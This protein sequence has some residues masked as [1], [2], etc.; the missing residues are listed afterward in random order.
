MAGVVKSIERLD[1]DN[2]RTWS[3]KMKAVLVTKELWTPVTED[4]PTDKK[5]DQKALALITL[6]VSDHNLSTL[7]EAETA[8]AAWETL[9]KVYE[10]RSNARK[11]QLKRELNALKK[12]AAETVTAYVTR[13][14]DLRIQLA[15]TGYEVK[16]EEVVLSLLAGLPT[17][18][19]MIVTVLES[20][21]GKLVLND[22]LPKLLPVEQRV[23]PE[24]IK[25]WISKG[26]EA[27]ECYYCHKKGHLKKDCRQKLRDKASSPQRSN[28]VFTRRGPAKVEQRR[29]YMDNVAFS[30]RGPA[31]VEHKK[32]PATDCTSRGS[33]VAFSMRGP[34]MVEQ[35]EI[36]ATN[37]LY[38]SLHD[39]RGAKQA[40][41][42]EVSAEEKQVNKLQKQLEELRAQRIKLAREKVDLDNKL[43]TSTT[44]H[45]PAPEPRLRGSCS[46]RRSWTP[47][48]DKYVLEE[49]LVDDTEDMSNHFKEELITAKMAMDK[50]K[51]RDAR[52]TLDL[53][54][55]VERS[56]KEL[57]N[58]ENDRRA[59]EI[60]AAEMRGRAT[61][62]KEA[63]LADKRAAD[64][65]ADK[66]M[67]CAAYWMAKFN[68]CK[69]EDG[70]RDVDEAQE[71]K[72]R[73]E[74]VEARMEAMLSFFTQL[75]IIGAV[76]GLSTLMATRPTANWQMAKGANWLKLGGVNIDLTGYCDADHGGI[77]DT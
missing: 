40:L 62:E 24:E 71:W 25:A 30:V 22:L 26:P 13:A 36:T 33:A 66:Y 9:K 49:K 29:K 72:Q 56:T 51:E 69:A 16:D 28:H 55:S 48:T 53:M 39:L 57:K 64:A 41:T 58:V 34:S 7:D 75:D 18:Y 10:A 74:A 67:E 61:A 4:E 70:R 65:R 23:K 46:S 5:A 42:R 45:R 60:A 12:D 20:S 37:K 14:K 31:K 68:S 2:Y 17:E 76:R 54:K 21:D 8:K 15:S 77:I 47:S 3:K 73:Y 35:E 63:L 43:A 38:E 11:L 44:G 32:E 27:R 50:D 59:A 6:S 1:V 19:D 52:F